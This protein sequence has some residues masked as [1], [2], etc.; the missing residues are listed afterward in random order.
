MKHFQV[1]PTKAVM[2]F[3]RAEQLGHTQS[4]LSAHG[5]LSAASLIL[6]TLVGV[7]CD[8]NEWTASL[9][10]DPRLCCRSGP[11]SPANSKLAHLSAY[12]CA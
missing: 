1:D 5:S 2:S 11:R 12:E 7:N 4:L 10:G 9:P 8:A 6:P 3:E